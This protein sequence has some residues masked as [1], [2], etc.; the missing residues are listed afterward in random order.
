M[1]SIDFSPTAAEHLEGVKPFDRKRIL[2][3]IEEQLAHEP[4]R[5]TRR[6]KILEG[7]DPQ[8]QQVLPVW[9]LR[10]GD[11]R[12][13]YDVEE[14]SRTVIVHAILYKDRKTTGEIL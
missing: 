13:F 7:L 3:E 1:Y 12:V 2:D 5:K 14:E 11:Y 6:K 10:I 4:T 9:Q 8:W